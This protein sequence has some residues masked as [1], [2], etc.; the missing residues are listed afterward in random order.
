MIKVKRLIELLKQLPENA[1]VWAYEG[2]D[3][4]LAIQEFHPT[5]A[6]E[7]CMWW[8]RAKDCDDVEYTEGFDEMNI[9]SHKFMEFSK[10]KS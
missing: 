8:I 1:D 6:V 7:D 10:N 5:K 3:T 2:G 9:P 4:G